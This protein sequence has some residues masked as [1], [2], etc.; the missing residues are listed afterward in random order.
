[1][2]VRETKIGRGYVLL[3]RV[4]HSD[5]FKAEKKRQEEPFQLFF[6]LATEEG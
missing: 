4:G 2:G 5:H 6:L 3:G 1:M